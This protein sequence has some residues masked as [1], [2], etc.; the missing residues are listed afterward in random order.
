MGRKSSIRRQSPDVRE[1]IAAWN[2]EGRTLDEIAVA[3]E[4]VFAV[5]LSR[6]AV[7]RHV[8]GLEKHLAR[9][10]RSRA[11]AEATV[12][13]FGQES[14][15][16][17]TRANI[18]LVHAMISEIGDQSEIDEGPDD[19]KERAKTPMG[20]MLLAKAVEH[21]T[22]AG[23]HDAE[24]VA[25]IRAEVR[26]EA[27]KAMKARADELCRVENLKDLSNDDLKRKIAELA[28]GI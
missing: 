28:A 14:D 12:A 27:E 25:K 11:I 13:R 22:K 8:K 5:K 2:R 10:E 21:L 4:E 9:I 23:R 3:L 6:S 17:V 16:K 24:L 20:A 26:K 1:A 15:S 7:H 18:E 19:D